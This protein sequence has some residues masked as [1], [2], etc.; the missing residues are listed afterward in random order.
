M[1][2]KSNICGGLDEVYSAERGYGLEKV[3]GK[4]SVITSNGFTLK[5]LWYSLKYDRGMVI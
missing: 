2:M 1:E 4:M 5:K 3:G